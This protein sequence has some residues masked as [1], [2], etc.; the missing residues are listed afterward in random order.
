M[1]GTAEEADALEVELRI[2]IATL[3]AGDVVHPS[4]TDED[5]RAW[6]TEG[7]A[8]SAKSACKIDIDAR[9]GHWEAVDDSGNHLRGDE[10]ALSPCR[11]WVSE[12]AR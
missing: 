1:R 2:E 3:K 8:V 4:P 12:D 10:A 6:H 7:R 11:W 5:L 9:G